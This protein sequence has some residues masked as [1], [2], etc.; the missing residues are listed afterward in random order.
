MNDI[1][2][3][4]ITTRNERQTNYVHQGWSLTAI[5]AM[6]PWTLSRIARLNQTNHVET[7]VSKRVINQRLQVEATLADLIPVPEFEDDVSA[8]LNKTTRFEKFK[9]LYKVFEHW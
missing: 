5:N 4:V 9:E 6:S 8:A 1:V 3:D 7:F 2:T